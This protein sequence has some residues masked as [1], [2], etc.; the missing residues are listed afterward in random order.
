MTDPNYDP[1]LDPNANIDAPYMR[2]GNTNSAHR[3]NTSELYN[4]SYI[5]L[6]TLQIGY[7]LPQALTK[8]AYINKLRIF[9]SFENLLTITS[10][11][12]VDPEMSGSGF[13]SYPIPRMISGGI[14]ITF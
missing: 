9:A 7:T 13:Q 10:F 1:A 5:K 14:N 3:A 2:I 8:K 12:G 4:A 6:K 11:P